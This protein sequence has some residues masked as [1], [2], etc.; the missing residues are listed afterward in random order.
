[1]ANVIEDTKSKM[2]A[3]ID[4]LKKDL[5][6]IRTGR[7]HSGI[8]ENVSVEVYGTPMRLRDI[9][10]IST[11]EPR[12]IL[13]T[14]FDTKNAPVIG[15]AIEK[16]N[17]GLNPIVDAKAVRVNIP[18][19][20]AQMRNEMIKVCH[21]K[22][23]ETKVSIRTIRQNVRKHYTDS[24]IAEDE[25]KKLDKQVQELTDQFCKEADEVSKHKENEISTI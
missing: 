2:R 7:A 1:M 3:A 18:P 8:V 11:P 13:I 16:A 20:D 25:K 6:Q 24:D 5:Q 22:R 4:H 19:M 17:L 9:A 15:K 12:L 10:S 23:E 14:P 21:K